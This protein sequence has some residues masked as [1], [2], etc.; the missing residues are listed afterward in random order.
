MKWIKKQS[1]KLFSWFIAQLVDILSYIWEIL[2]RRR[3]MGTYP[4]FKNFILVSFLFVVVAFVGWNI[5]LNLPHIEIAWPDG[6]ITVEQQAQAKFEAK[7]TIVEKVS[8]T[9][10]NSAVD[11]ISEKYGASPVLLKKI[12]RAES[13]NNPKAANKESSARGCFQFIISTWEEYGRKLWG[14]DFYEKNRYNPEHNVEL[15]SWMIGDL[16]ELSHWNESK[17]NWSK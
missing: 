2:S 4:K 6:R 8:I 11:A 16:G 5:T 13:G 15:A 9:D 3:Y 10:C 12:V 17:H 7:E 1:K 14:D